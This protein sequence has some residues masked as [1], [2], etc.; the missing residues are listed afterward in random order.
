MQGSRVI[1]TL[2]SSYS[3]LGQIL[4]DI[5][6]RGHLD[7]GQDL[8][9]HLGALNEDGLAI[10]AGSRDLTLTGGERDMPWREPS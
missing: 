6:P 1:A 10:Y 2:Q 4:S 5:G 8:D 7:A 3:T 9:D